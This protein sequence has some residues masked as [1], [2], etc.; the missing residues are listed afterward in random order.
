MMLRR[1][2]P[3]FFMVPVVELGLIFLMAHFLGWGWAIGITVASSVLGG[4][5]AKR[6]GAKWWQTVRQ[7]W[8]QEGFPVERLGE[9]A[10]LLL[11]MAF[12]I[13]P[14]PLTGIIGLIMMVPKIRRR[15]ADWVMRRIT[16]RISS[17][18]WSR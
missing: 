8:I 12:L 11:S 2:L 15:T 9:G 5:L 10:L 1:I 6:N 3:I 17:K 7:E 13:T 16:A 4:Y 18:W 14:G